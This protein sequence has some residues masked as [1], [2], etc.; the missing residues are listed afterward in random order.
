MHHHWNILS[1]KM[2]DLSVLIIYY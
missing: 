1:L 2:I